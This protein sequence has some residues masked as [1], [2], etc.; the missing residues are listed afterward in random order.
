MNCL[1]SETCFGILAVECDLYVEVLDWYRRFGGFAI[2]KGRVC[3]ELQ[4]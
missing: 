4:A 3:V 2:Y 1:M